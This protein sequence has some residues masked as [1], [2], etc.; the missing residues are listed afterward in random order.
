MIVG[1]FLYVDDT[2]LLDVCEQDLQNMLN[3]VSE[4]CWKW[5]LAITQGENTNCSF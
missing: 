1:V 5:R 4:W 3:I 2:I